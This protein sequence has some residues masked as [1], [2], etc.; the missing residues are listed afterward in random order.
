M[1]DHWMAIHTILWE[2]YFI[3]V[4]RKSAHTSVPELTLHVFVC[5]VS[6]AAAS[7]SAFTSGFFAEVTTAADER[8]AHADVAAMMLQRGEETSA[9]SSGGSTAGVQ[10]A[11]M[12]PFGG[13]KKGTLD[14]LL[15]VI[16]GPQKTGGC[17][18]LCVPW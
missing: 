14:G 12:F 11:L 18:D 13:W 9:S 16:R 5:Q 8:A 2:R 7:A 1:G 3:S 15:R 17:V 6:R 10:T 4:C